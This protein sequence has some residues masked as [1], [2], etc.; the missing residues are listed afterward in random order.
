[1]DSGGKL[2]K[3]TLGFNEVGFEAMDQRSEA[4]MLGPFGVPPI[5][6]GARIGLKQATMANY[7]ES[8]RQ[9]WEDTIIPELQ[10]YESEV[11]YYLTG[12]DD[13]TF[14]RFDKSQVPALRQDVSKQTESAYKLWSM[15][16]PVNQAAKI[17]GMAIDPVPGGDVGYLP[18]SVQPLG[19]NGLPIPPKPAPLPV[20]PVTRLGEPMAKPAGEAPAKPADQT[21][22]G[23]ANATEEVR[24]SEQPPFRGKEQLDGAGEGERLDDAGQDG[25]ELGAAVC[26]RGGGDV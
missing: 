10:L 17:V 9:C 1:M 8:R 2:E 12:Q 16:I 6:I 18:L 13:E 15:G 14:L 4:R 26:D 20:P 5:L 19:K 7:A 3:L 11:D 24:K 25:R 22:E 23:G 21:V